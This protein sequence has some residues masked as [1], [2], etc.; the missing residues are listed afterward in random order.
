M[1]TNGRSYCYERQFD[2]LR[3]VSRLSVV[4][5]SRPLTAASRANIGIESARVRNVTER[6]HTTGLY[7]CADTT[8]RR[9]RHVGTRTR[10]LDA[11][12]VRV[13]TR[14]NS[15]GCSCDFDSFVHSWHISSMQ[16]ISREE[17]VAG[18]INCNIVIRFYIL[19][20][21]NSKSILVKHSVQTAYVNIK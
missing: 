18:M 5:R 14:R 10:A 19:S 12:P 3:R 16:I 8:P 6:R 21:R 1:R 17:M 20:S 15:E 9:R 4:D 7:V 13:P 2:C 11:L